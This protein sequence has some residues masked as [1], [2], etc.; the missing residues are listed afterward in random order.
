MGDRDR[1]GIEFIV[2][3]LD[4]SWG[5]IFIEPRARLTLKQM[6]ASLLFTQQMGLNDKVYYHSFWSKNS[7]T[8]NILRI[9]SVRDFLFNCLQMRSFCCAGIQFRELAGENINQG[10]KSARRQ[11]VRNW[12]SK[13]CERDGKQN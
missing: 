11:K 6:C 4:A 2:A 5:F 12:S 10:Q 1:I 8:E 3:R 13:R 9:W 7:L